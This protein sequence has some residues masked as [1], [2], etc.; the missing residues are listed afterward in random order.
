MMNVAD[1]LRT[2]NLGQYEAAFR[3][4][5]VGMDVLPSLTA[6][7]LK[8]LGI[9]AVG[10]RRRLLNAIAELRP[11]AERVGAQNTEGPPAERR[12]L[13]V[14]F[15]DIAG[16]TALSIRLDP[17]DLSAV[18]R[19]YQS[20]VRSTI[21]RFGGFIARYVGDGVLIYFGWPEAHETDA[22]SAVRA[23]IATIAAVNESP[24]HGEH[25]SIRIG[26]ATGLVVVGA[27][28]G[29][30]DARQHTAIG[31]TPNLAARLQSLAEPNAV[32]I[33][34]GTRR[35]VGD[36]FEYRDLGMLEMKGIAAPVPAWQV[37]RPSTIESRFE[38]LHPAQL[39]P[40][41]GRE[42][43][44]ELLGRRWAQAKAGSGRV[45]LVSAEPGFGK[46][47]LAEAFQD[48]V[49]GER[50]TRL[51][52]F[53]SPHHQDSA[54]LPF[55]AQLEHAAGFARDDTPAVRLGKLETLLA[56]N[57][58]ERDVSLLAE[59][60]SLPFDNRYPLFDFTPQR[61]KEETF[62]A[63]LRQFAGL[64]RQQPVLMIF[65][66][67]HWADPTSRELLDRTVERVARM[68]VLLVATFRPEVEPP[69]T[70]QS[71][72]ETL[73][74]RRLGRGE[75]GKL[76][77]E[78]VGS[79][80]TLSREVVDEIVERT[81]GVP[82]FLEELTKAVVE[83]S[84][85]RGNAGQAAIL[86]VS[87][88]SPAIPATLHA[89]LM[90]RLDRLGPT[91][92]E[93]LQFGAAIGRDFSYELLAAVGQWTDWELR[94]ALARLVAAGLVF[95]HNM[96]TRASFIFKH[97]LVQDIAYSMLLLGVR[98][99]LH[100]RIA[101][102]LEERFS[103]AM[104]A[105]P[106][107]LAHHFTEAGLFEKAVEYWCRAG[108]QSVAKSG[109][110]EAIAQLKTGLRLIADLPDTRERKQQELQLQIT[111][112]G[113]L[114]VV[115]GYAH[116]EVAASSSRARNLILETGRMGT[117]THF[118]V[119]RALWAADFVGGKPKAALDHANEFLS[120]AQSQTDSRVSAMGHW[121]VGRVFIAIG[122][123][124]A[125]SSHLESAVASYR[126][127]KDETFDPRLGADIGVTAVAAW[128]L[129]LWHRGYPDQA[130]KATDEALRRAR[131]LRHLHTLVYALL[132][133]GL[134]AISARNT[135]WAEEL[136]NEL[137]ALSD[138][139]RFAFFSGF[140]QIFQ[141]WALAHRGQGQAAVQRIREGLSAAEATGW[142][143]HEPGFLGLLAEALALNGAVS[144]G[145]TVLA[146]ALATAK[147]SAARGADAEIYRLRGELLQRL[148]SPDAREV[149]ACFRTALAV[150]R[151]QGTH[152][153]EL[154]A[155]T[156]LA[157]LLRNQGRL[158]D[159]IACLQPIYDRFTEGFGTT[160]LI[161]A[162]QLLDEP[163]DPAR[164]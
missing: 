158:A 145:L 59:L 155:A 81:D 23:A 47:R 139:N 126:A 118:S 159:A 116:R 137:V 14:M 105:R 140:G 10:D 17:E 33:A 103:D 1:W 98:R 144:D 141:G 29:A 16:S 71:H 27:P 90:A 39:T 55:I 5:S 93:I 6:D 138:K 153:Y 164:H 24:V 80:E 83:T 89:S 100:G 63:L 117:I 106:E 72:V 51:R 45:V 96:P 146:E 20:T 108:R 21:S 134:A 65:E 119:L 128:G 64:A 131:Q 86:S 74:L 54:L 142:R 15:C 112:T 136:A 58:V 156:S 37:L 124:P 130:R 56:P 77:R 99:S 18:V 69:W 31:E 82:L 143:S 87:A 38:A 79:A 114:T 68:R 26:I 48:K 35:L 70:G 102:A 85:S 151:E 61:K 94:S 53:C 44:L 163:G 78:I 123:Y 46:S 109:F 25:L 3:E 135:A 8:N 162:K 101:R 30:G 95:K 22:E 32:V 36:L 49:E 12:Q 92:K 148:P 42:E 34:A 40:L 111:L 13:T 120:L 88:V 122:D 11:G 67:L 66:D 133:I 19:A 84:S 62:E 160:D 115:K 41:V 4:N 147:A 161:G 75:S 154:R 110:I 132:I 127:G 2:L 104:Q 73:S 150:A 149:E 97:A 50:R 76:V 129:A 152:G 43:E 7:D 52:Y 60:L 57:A 28:I 113:A 91:A 121:L 157:R 9:N 107:T 125:A